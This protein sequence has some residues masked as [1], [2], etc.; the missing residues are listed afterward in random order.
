MIP[1][2]CLWKVV[3]FFGKEHVNCSSISGV[4]IRRSWKFKFGKLKIGV[5]KKV[6]DMIFQLL[7]I[8]NPQI[9][10][11]L[12]CSLPKNV[13]TFHGQQDGIIHFC[14]SPNKRGVLALWIYIFIKKIMDFSKLDCST[15][16]YHNSTNTGLIDM[17][18][19]KKY[20]YFSQETRWNHSFLSHSSLKGVLAQ[21]RKAAR[22]DC[23]YCT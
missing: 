6:M 21:K 19:T 18:L 12:T 2:C 5:T 1:S 17:F 11:Q 14:L 3:T 10:E 15:S 9:L 20:N 4:M 7:P 13:T 22:F 23:R 16:S 8:I